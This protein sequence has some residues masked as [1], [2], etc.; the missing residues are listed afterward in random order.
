MKSKMYKMMAVVAM[1]GVC[2]AGCGQAAAPA[3]T[4]QKEEAA[5]AVA[6]QTE[7]EAEK[8]ESNPYL[9]TWGITAIEHD[10]AKLSIEEAEAMGYDY[11]DG[12]YVILKDGGEG[13]YSE[14]RI[15]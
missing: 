5:Q 7:T 10:G 6:D 13:S 1:I 14:R 2:T 9:G 4:E 15:L 8:S 3:P 11:Y 12:Y